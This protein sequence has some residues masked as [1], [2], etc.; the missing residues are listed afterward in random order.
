MADTQTD[1]ACDPKFNA[2]MNQTMAS[3]NA[4]IKKVVKPDPV[5]AAHMTKEADDLQ[6]KSDSIAFPQAKPPAPPDTDP[7]KV[8]GSAGGWIATLG[9]ILTR[10]PLTSALHASAAAINAAKAG[11]QKAYENKV[12]EWEEG[13]ELIKRQLDWINE[14]FKGVT[15]EEEL[16]VRAH[17]A[18]FPGIDSVFQGPDGAKNAIKMW[19]D[20][21][22]LYLEKS[23]LARE[24]LK[25]E[26]D[27]EKKFRNQQIQ[28]AYD[29]AISEGKNPDEARDIAL[30]KGGASRD[31][32]RGGGTDSSAIDWASYKPSD[33]VPGTGHTFASIK[34][35]ADSIVNGA[36]YAEEGLS[37]RTTKNPLKD[38]IDNYIGFAHPD[39]DT[40]SA[41]GVSEKLEKAAYVRD[42]MEQWQK[43][44]PKASKI[45]VDQKKLELQN[46]ADNIVKGTSTSGGDKKL[47]PEAQ[48]VLDDDSR[49]YA[50]G[51]PITQIVK[52]YGKN[53]SQRL[54]QIKENAIRLGLKPDRTQSTIDYTGNLS[55]NR[56]E[57]GRIGSRAGTTEVAVGEFDELIEPTRASIHKLDMGSFKD[58]NEFVQSYD[59]HFNDPDYIEAFNNI[60]EL[61]N[62]Y[63]SVL[64]R[65]GQRTDAAQALSEHTLNTLFGVKGSDRALDTMAANTKRILKGIKKAK[66]GTVGKADGIP[67][68]APTATGDD[69]KKMYWDGTEWVLAGGK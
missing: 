54:E 41:K 7:W 3:E 29:K 27:L 14:K 62:A 23:K 38:A 5:G 57:K 44:N 24:S 9:S 19:Q 42:S 1:F 39:F 31:E 34:Q 65:G 21:G 20:N 55:Q 28:S 8:M 12:K 35:K 60:Q 46:E 66:D 6:Q 59:Q 67:P 4:F 13:D 51:L 33:E 50:K 17:A 56:S 69:G 18:G 40:V 61:Q 68:G 36:T 64:T 10:Q 22:K 2:F 52:G 15:N 26:G 11:D 48:A 58:Y 25:G 32:G 43:D 45:E 37:T 53:A 16:R 49:D 47:S 30:K 63:T